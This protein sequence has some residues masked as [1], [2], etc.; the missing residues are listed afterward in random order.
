[1]PYVKRKIAQGDGKEHRFAVA[2]AYLERI[3]GRGGFSPFLLEPIELNQNGLEWVVQPYDMVVAI[4]LAAMPRAV[5]REFVAAAESPDW[6]D[7]QL[8]GKGRKGARFA[9]DTGI[10]MRSATGDYESWL[11]LGDYFG[12]AEDMAVR[13]AA[14]DSAAPAEE[15]ADGEGEVSEDGEGV[16]EGSDEDP[17]GEDPAAGKD[18]E[19]EGHKAV[20]RSMAAALHRLPAKQWCVTAVASFGPS[21]IAEIPT[22]VLHGVEILFIGKPKSCTLTSVL[23]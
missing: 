2:G 12:M 6:R 10:Y 23:C 13:N 19:N 22:A 14:H 4:G 17:S 5:R 11:D 16:D 1:M 15:G 20:N 9:H 21:R 3:Q 7:V 8:R 18:D